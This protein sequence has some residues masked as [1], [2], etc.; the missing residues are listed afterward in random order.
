[1]DEKVYIN[2]EAKVK[3]KVIRGK[4]IAAATCIVLAPETFDLAEDGIVFAKEGT[5]NDA[6]KIIEAAKSCPTTAI[7]VE[8]LEGKQLYPQKA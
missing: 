8:D 3:I 6:A 1:M 2:K 5:W 4:C 7:I